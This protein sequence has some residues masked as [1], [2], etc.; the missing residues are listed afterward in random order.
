MFYCSSAFWCVG[1]LHD[2]YGEEVLKDRQCRNWFDK[3][4]SE[5][6]LLK[7]E[8]RSGRPNEIDDDQNKAIIESDRYVIV[9]EIK[10]MLKIP[11]STID[12]HIKRLGLF[13]KT[14]YLDSTWIERNSFNKTHQRLWFASWTIILIR[15]FF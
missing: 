13:K 11:K 6:F 7:D 1:L 9:W 10:E 8:Q 12:R 3:F 2:V 14:W 4:R 15:S 5:D